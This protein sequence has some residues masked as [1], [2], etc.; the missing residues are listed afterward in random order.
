[1]P[2]A[3]RLWASGLSTT[4]AGRPATSHSARPICPLVAF[5]RIGRDFSP[6]THGPPINLR[7]Q[8][9]SSAETTNLH[10]RA[11][12][13]L[14]RVGFSTFRRDASHR[15]GL[16][17]GAPGASPLGTTPPACRKPTFANYFRP[18]RTAAPITSPICTPKSLDTRFKLKSGANSR[19]AHR[20]GPSLPRIQHPQTLVLC[21]FHRCPFG[22]RQ[23]AGGPRSLLHG[24][25]RAWAG[26][27]PGLTPYPA[28][29][30]G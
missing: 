25:S 1:V 15:M 18:P 17:P 22:S 27:T 10:P 3:P 30:C 2:P 11:I 13:D 26:P 6:G 7:A 5:H 20:A 23:L 14:S 12:A 29:S 24:L 4:A 8:P 19:R 9:I 16:P 28:R 21:Q